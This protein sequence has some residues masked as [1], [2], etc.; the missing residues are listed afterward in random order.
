[1]LILF[2]P[3]EK[4][5]NFQRMAIQMFEIFPSR[6]NFIFDVCLQFQLVGT[7]LIYKGKLSTSL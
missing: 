6:Y 2:G 3:V 1:M 7:T 4:Q 5:N